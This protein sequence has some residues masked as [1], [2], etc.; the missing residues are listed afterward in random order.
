MRWAATIALVACLIAGPAASETRRVLSFD[1]LDGWAADNHT[2]ALEVFRKTCGDMQAPDWSAICAVAA[3]ARDAR[4]FFEMFFRPVLIEDGTPPLITGYYEPELTGAR[5]P[6]ARFRYPV[7]RL[8]PEL[9]DGAI[10]PTRA[11]IETGGV[12]ADRGL[13]IAWTD[14]PVGL[15]YMQV[16]GSGRIR[17]TDGT[18]LRLGFAGANGYAYR[19][20]GDELVRRGIYAAH[21]VSSRV[22]RNWVRR[23]PVA[24]HELLLGSPSYV[25]FRVIKELGAGI[26]PRGAMNRSITAGRSVAVDPAFVP[27]GAPVWLEKAG[28]APLR[29]LVVAQDTGS[30]IKGAQRADLFTGS[31]ADAGQ[32][33]AQIKDRGRLV[34]LLPID[35][36]FAMAREF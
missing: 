3:D 18:I 20:P 14:D 1:D 25:F 29:K 7:Y 23:N 35:M 33:A 13:E 8:P 32:A 34:V 12:L 17:L 15:F 30:A 5:R 16:Q 22:I 2:A 9:A 28:R 4:R 36:A 27:L 24:G 31:G 26:G 6:S 11:E 19:S 21:Q 10:G